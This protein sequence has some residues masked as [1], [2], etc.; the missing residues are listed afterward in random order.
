MLVRLATFNILH[1]AS[2]SDGRVDLD[3]FAAAVRSLD[4]DVL[5]LQEVDR[6]QPR[7]LSA[8]LTSVAA[9]AMQATAHRFVPA[10]AGTPGGWQAATGTEP[11]GLAGYGVALLSRFAVPQWRVVRL[12]ALAV[13]T[14]LLRRR[15]RP[16]LVRDEPRVAVVAT[17]LASTGRVAVVSTHLSYVC[18]WNLVQLGRLRR[19]VASWDGPL[20]VMGDLNMGP[21][22][23]ATLTGL[24]PL[25]AAP[26]FPAARPRRQIDHILARGLVP[27][28]PGRAVRL[29][30]SDHCALSVDVHD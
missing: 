10:L 22:P 28:G 14:P 16:R 29:P 6:A 15:R 18:G 21:R 1:G 7:S 30:V 11:A 12:P 24:R 2:P 3:G 25:A 17:M 20:V 19:A 5:A 26:T 4:A 27:D 13:S 9:A 23:A 8:D